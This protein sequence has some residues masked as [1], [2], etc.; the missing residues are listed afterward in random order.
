M[1][2]WR[3]DGDDVINPRNEIV[4][5]IINGLSSIRR[6]EFIDHVLDGPRKAAARVRAEFEEE[7]GIDGRPRPPYQPNYAV[8][9]LNPTDGAAYTIINATVGVRIAVEHLVDKVK[10]MR[11]LCGS[12]VVPVVKL[13]ATL[14][15]TKFGG[16]MR[17]EFKVIRYVELRMQASVT[18]T[19]TKAIGKPGAFDLRGNHRG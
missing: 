10:Y 5:K 15:K 16:R 7:V 18:A 1:S 2:G 11:M 13:T 6:A 3:I 17:P 9:M 19:E 8:Y 4:A 14:M 12:R